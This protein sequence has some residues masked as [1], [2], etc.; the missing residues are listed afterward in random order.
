[1][2]AKKEDPASTVL[3]FL[4]G[5][6]VGVGVYYL[7][8]GRE[9]PQGPG[10]TEAGPLLPLAP[11]AA[12]ANLTDIVRRL[13]EVRENY[14]MG[15]LAPQETLTQVDG[16]IVAAQTFGAQGRANPADVSTV[17][18]DLGRFR[19]DVVEFMIVPA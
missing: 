9:A 12:F 19:R 5:G 13:N 4:F 6:A 11:P 14:R 15:R 10:R 8:K 1:M 2:A 18:N 7:L 16:L 3:W 17:V